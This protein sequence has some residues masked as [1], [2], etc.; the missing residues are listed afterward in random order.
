MWGSICVPPEAKRIID[1]VPRTPASTN[2][3][4][5]DGL[6]E[7]EAMGVPREEAMRVGLGRFPI[8][9]RAN[10]VHDWLYPRFGP[11]FRF[12][13]GTDVFADHGTPLQ[14]P[15]DGVATSNN[16]GLGGLTVRI[17][18]P[19]G[20]YIYMAHLSGLAEGFQQGMQVSVGD[21][22]GYVGDSGNARGGAPH[23]HIGIY[24][25]GG[26]AIDPKPLL[27]R[28]LAEAE[29]RLPMVIEA[30]RDAYGVD[31][32]PVTAPPTTAPPPPSPPPPADVPADVSPPAEDA[33]APPDEDGPAPEAEVEVE[34][35]DELDLGVPSE[36]VFVTGVTSTPVL[37]SAGANPFGGALS[38]LEAEI[39]DVAAGIDWEARARG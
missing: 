10:Y 35:A 7:L 27:D 21:V 34:P 16:G 31:G 23:L 1:S 36:P 24:P 25:R 5:L 32:P 22:I 26:P 20:T 14:A 12:H 33:P 15:V 38:M 18:M 4:L 17:T 2:H 29:A 30:F 19:D 37:F 6:A 11:G 13:Q 28:W 9:G 3:R 39:A 8:A